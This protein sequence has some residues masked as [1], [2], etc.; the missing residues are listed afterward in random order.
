MFLEIRASVRDR[1]REFLADPNSGS[2]TD[3]STTG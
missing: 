3:S 2:A 1:F